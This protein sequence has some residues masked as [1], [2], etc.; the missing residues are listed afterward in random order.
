MTD[1]STA[2]VARWFRHQL[3]Q[4]GLTTVVTT[5]YLTDLPH[6]LVVA[7]EASEHGRYYAELFLSSHAGPRSPV[8]APQS[9]PPVTRSTDSGGDQ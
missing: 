9:R 4:G 1:I 3:E 7:I 6:D 2:D 8:N 5:G